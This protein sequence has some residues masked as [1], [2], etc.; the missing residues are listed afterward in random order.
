MA[1]MAD[2][3][4]RARAT[5]NDTVATYRYSDAD[6]LAYA[7]AGVQRAYQVRPDLRFGAYSTTVSDLASGGTFP[8]PLGYLQAVADYVVFRAETRDDEHVNSQRAAQFMALF[9]KLILT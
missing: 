5:L 1:T 7:N 3:I 4:T 2:V 9:D 6:L 8:L